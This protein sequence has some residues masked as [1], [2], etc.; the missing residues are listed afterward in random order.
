MQKELSKK[1]EIALVGGGLT[2]YMMATILHHSGYD[3]VWFSGP[4][5][6][7]NTARDTRTTTLHHVGMV[8]LKTLGVWDALAADAWPLTDIY[9]KIAERQGSEFGPFRTK[10]ASAWPLHFNADNLAMGYVVDNQD[11]KDALR[12][13]QNKLNAIRVPSRT[14]PL[15]AQTN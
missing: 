14:L 10:E 5:N 11:L 4:E 15:P 12:P 1:C 9:V 6:T 7:Q 13:L 8:M 2:T 3:F